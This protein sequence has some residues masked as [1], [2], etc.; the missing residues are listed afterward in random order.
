MSTAVPLSSRKWKNRGETNI[1]FF[2]LKTIFLFICET[3]SEYEG[4]EK[5]RN[6]VSRTNK[7]LIPSLKMIVL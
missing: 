4:T 1:F 7:N 6:G 3:G 2:Y 5:E